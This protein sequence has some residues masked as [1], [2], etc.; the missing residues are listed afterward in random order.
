M[1]A[2][3]QPR[4][5]AFAGVCMLLL[6]SAAA[7]RQFTVNLSGPVLSYVFDSNTRSLRPV[8]GILGSS[9]IG[10]PLDFGFTLT[11]ALTLDSRR[12]IAA[13]ESYPN[14]LIIDLERNSPS[15]AAIPGVPA[16]PSK[17]A[18]SPRG[19]SGAFYYPDLRGIWIVAGLPRPATAPLF[20][21]LSVSAA[22]T[23]M[24]VSDDGAQ[25]IY[26]INEGGSE[27]VYAWTASS[28]RARFLMSVGSVG[29]LTITGN[30]DA[31]VADRAANE[32]FVIRDLGGPAVPQLL[33][34]PR[35]GVSDPIGVAV[36]ADGIYI[37]NAASASVMAL[38]TD[39]RLLKTYD[40]TCAVSGLF[41]F[42]DS[43]FRLTTGLD[44][45]V[46]LFDA[47]SEGRIL[48]VPKP[49]SSQ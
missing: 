6:T 30:R 2:S 29:G 18:A 33:A 5:L 47:S 15:I 16:T 38:D 40:C 37:A 11:Q 35:E 45:S 24:A 26:A 32:V 12:L 28:T 9:T 21:D 22:I 43:V 17:T 8:L 44:R 3:I 23:H 36:S 41:S 39:G 27:G 19:T 13:T 31:L 34:G 46:W 42:T 20:V 48:F 7:A 1:S 4:L 14:L 49:E 25:L 10:K